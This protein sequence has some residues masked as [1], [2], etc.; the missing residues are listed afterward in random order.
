[1]I[2]R[3]K[4]KLKRILESLDNKADLSN[5]RGDFVSTPFR[6]SKKQRRHSGRRYPKIFGPQRILD[7]EGIFVDYYWDEWMDWRDGWRYGSDKTHL[8]KK[9]CSWMSREERKKSNNKIKKQI[10]IRNAKK[11]KFSQKYIHQPNL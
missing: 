11:R 3:R 5:N 9:G 1:M 7:K 4:K 2:S 6:L 8:F 10:V